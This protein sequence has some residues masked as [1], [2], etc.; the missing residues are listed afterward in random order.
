MTSSIS[1]NDAFRET[2][3]EGIPMLAMKKSMQPRSGPT[4]MIIKAIH[5]FPE[6]AE[7]S[8]PADFF[9]VGRFSSG[10]RFTA[11]SVGNLKY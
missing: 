11:E 5:R 9:S 1:L 4:K 2:R 7:E 10:V 3:M 8:V 6:S